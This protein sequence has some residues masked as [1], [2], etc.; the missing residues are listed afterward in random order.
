[1][2]LV[3]AS[4]RASCGLGITRQFR[5]ALAALPAALLLAGCGVGG[6]G[7]S[8][9]VSASGSLAITVAAVPGVGD[10]PLYIARRDGLFRQHGL[11]VTIRN[12][13][14]LEQEIPA[15]SSGHADIAA[16]D[17]ADFFYQENH[18]HLALRL[19]A[20]GYDAAPNVMEVLTLPTSHITSPQDLVNKTIATPMPQ[21]INDS[22]NVPDSLEMMATQ[23]VL[24][25]DG[26]GP[27]SITWQPTPQRDMISALSTG[28]VNAIL[29]TE[30]YIFEAESRLG[31]VA[32]L[33]SCSGVTANLPLL[34]YFSMSAFAHEHPQAVRAFRSALLQAQ[35]DAAMRGPVQTALTE[36][37]GI[38]SQD[39]PLLTLGVYPTFLSVG[40]VQRVADLM[41]DAG[42]I[43]TPLAIQKLVA[44]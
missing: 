3:P 28:K 20:D 26:V 2:R 33:D 17:Y 25:N 11:D 35:A 24:R 5:R 13:T 8:A 44:R 10:A 37:V 18:A 23:A 29:T 27:T 16:G 30:P 1:M 34:G 21:A 14:S 19:I 39:A 4:A 31:A 42:M 38:S 41:Y 22:S 9:N 6:G 32:V 40:Q 7:T 15:L 43:S 12:Y 36:S